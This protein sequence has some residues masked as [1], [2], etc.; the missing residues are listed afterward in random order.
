MSSI[1]L[2]GIPTDDAVAVAQVGF[3]RSDEDRDRWLAARIWLGRTDSAFTE[4]LCAAQRARTLVQD[5]ID[6]HASPPRDFLKEQERY[7]VVV[8]HNLWDGYAVEDCSGGDAQSPHHDLGNWRSRLQSTGARYIFLFGSD[9]NI[10]SLQGY[11]SISVPEKSFLSVFALESGFR[12]SNRSSESIT[13]TDMSRARLSA[14]A[15]LLESETLELSY[16]E[17]DTSHLRTFREMACLKEL[18]LVGAGITD[19]N[20]EFVAQACR[21]E[22]LSLDENGIAGHGLSHLSRLTCLR[23]LSLDHVPIKEDALCHLIDLLRLESLSL[24]GTPV[25]DRGL[26]HLTGIQ[27][28]RSLFLLGTRVTENG[29]ERFRSAL[30]QCEVFPPWAD[31]G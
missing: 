2:A 23:V 22:S 6:L 21:L 30:P 4:R 19:S 5:V 20:L 11:E 1:A 14:L 29:V 28:L 12:Y 3:T 25:G 7:D 26:Q 27:S 16:T 8:V 17:P 18:R 10:A 13:F 9:F 15:E 31:V 24:I